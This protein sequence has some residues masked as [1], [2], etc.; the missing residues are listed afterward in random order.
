MG[1]LYLLELQPS[2]IVAHCRKRRRDG[3]VAPATQSQDVGYLGEV[4]RLARSYWNLPYS[5]DPVA[6]ARVILK[7]LVPIFG[8]AAFRRNGRVVYLEN[9]TGGAQ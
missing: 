6:D 1:K 9:I 5:A 7:R 2:D 3:C 8:G 4:L